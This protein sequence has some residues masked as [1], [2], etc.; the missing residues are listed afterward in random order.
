MSETFEKRKPDYILSYL[1]KDTQEKG[2][3]GQAWL[4]AD[5][6]ISIQLNPKVWI[7]QNK[8]EALRLFPNDYTETTKR[9]PSYKEKTYG[10]Q[11]E[12]EAPF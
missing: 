11:E 9:K 5:K 6:S 3:L 10:Q 8:N 4:N 2:R 1:N 7:E 12:S